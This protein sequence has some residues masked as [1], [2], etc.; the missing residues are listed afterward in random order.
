M[1][2]LNSIGPS[3]H[4][5]QSTGHDRPVR[6]PRRSRHRQRGALLLCG[7]SERPVQESCMLAFRQFFSSHLGV[8]YASPAPAPDAESRPSFLGGLFVGDEDQSGDDGDGMV[9]GGQSDRPIMAGRLLARMLVQRR[10]CGSARARNN[11][12]ISMR[13]L[14]LVRWRP[15]CSGAG[16]SINH[17][18]ADSGR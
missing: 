10:Q 18:I 5:Q 2:G 15:I 9:L 4:C 3:C 12:V 8:R 7:R 11:S 6:L 14:C 13:I 17:R 1:A 16:N